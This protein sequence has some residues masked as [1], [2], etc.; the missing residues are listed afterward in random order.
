DGDRGTDRV[1]RQHVGDAWKFEWRS[2]VPRASRADLGDRA[3]GVYTPG[4]AIREAGR[5]AGAGE[6]PGPLVLVPGDVRAT[7]RSRRRRGDPGS[8]RST[9]EHHR[10]DGK[11]RSLAEPFPR[12]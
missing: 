5:G 4:G 1:L 8:A 12:E 7:K 11:I 2:F 6:E 9:R 10:D 3:G